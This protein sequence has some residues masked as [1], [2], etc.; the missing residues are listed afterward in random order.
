MELFWLWLFFGITVD[1]L[2]GIWMIVCRIKFGGNYWFIV[3]F[4]D[5]LTIFWNIYWL[6]VKC[7]I[8]KGK[9]SN[10]EVYQLYMSV[11]V[12]AKAVHIF[13]LAWCSHCSQ[14]AMS[15]QDNILTGWGHFNLIGHLLNGPIQQCNNT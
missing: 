8:A 10:Y 7:L 4:N 15:L 9:S 2:I 6:Y 12:L 3:Y 14:S 13:K 5:Y 11:H 1:H